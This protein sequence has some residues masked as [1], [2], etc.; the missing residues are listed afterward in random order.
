MLVVIDDS[1]LAYPAFSS[2]CTYCKHWK[3]ENKRTCAA[4]P[5]GIPNEIWMGDDK[6]A[7]PRTGSE[8]AFED[9]RNEK[10]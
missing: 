7:T 3:P 5:D 4:F 2:V 6:H 1:E 9:I 10:T 8:F